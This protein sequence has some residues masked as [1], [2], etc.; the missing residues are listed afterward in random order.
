[1]AYSFSSIFSAYEMHKNILEINTEYAM[2]NG[3]GVQR[4]WTQGV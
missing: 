3:W 2:G 4:I 1:M